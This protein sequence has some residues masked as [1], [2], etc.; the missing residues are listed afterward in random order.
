MTG[1]GGH[2]SVGI[3]ELVTNSITSKLRRSGPHLRSARSC[4]ICK[5]PDRFHEM[6][7]RSAYIPLEVSVGPYHRQKESLKGEDGKL[8]FMLTLLTRK[9]NMKFGEEEEE[10]RGGNVVGVEE[11]EAEI[12]ELVTANRII[13]LGSSRMVGAPRGWLAVLKDCVAAIE[14]METEI[15]E[16]Y[17][18]LIEMESEEFVEMMVV[19][20]LFIIELLT[21]VNNKDLDPDNPLFAS[22]TY[23]A[24]NLYWDILLLENQLPIFALKELFILTAADDKVG[25]GDDDFYRLILNYLREDEMG[26]AYIHHEDL[27]RCKDGKHLLDIFSRELYPRLPSHVDQ[28][29]SVI[30]SL[31]SGYC[32]EPKIQE[33]K[34]KLIIPGAVELSRAGVLFKKRSSVEPHSFL[35]VKFNRNGIFEIPPLV[36]DDYTDRWLR[37]LIAFEQFRHNR[38]THMTAYAVLMDGLINSAKDVELLRNKGILISWLGSDEEVANMFNKLCIE[39]LRYNSIYSELYDEVNRYY[40][41]RRHKW[42]ATLKREYF[43]NPWSLCSFLAAVLLIL[44]TVTS[45]VFTALAWVVP[46]P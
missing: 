10:T 41:K 15:R 32:Y 30:C 14:K 19:D 21:E 45:T 23:A 6:M 39:I 24:A 11:K 42:Q 46:K 33:P 3:N 38:Y 2:V 1:D 12:E 43:N 9:A 31:Y 22:V 37:N 27:A 36:I 20:G 18:N 28:D 8:S 5:V 25:P 34:S 26:E 4:T 13:Q 7:E 44:L 16:C 17:S 29:D 40:M 35:D